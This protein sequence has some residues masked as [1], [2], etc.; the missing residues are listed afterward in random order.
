M[1]SNIFIGAQFVDG[2]VPLIH[3]AQHSIDIV[4]FDWRLYPQQPESPAGLLLHA[5]QNAHDRGVEVRVITSNEAVAAQLRQYGF[6]VE[7]L[8]FPRLVHAKVMIFDGLRAVLGSHNYTQAAFSQNI[9]VSALIDLGSVD[10]EL[11]R[12]FTNLWPLGKR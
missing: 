12:W 4:V 6:K 5:L 1:P 2:V 7:R 8:Y 10:N 3:S 9:E 11:T